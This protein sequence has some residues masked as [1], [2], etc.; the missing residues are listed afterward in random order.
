M[1][2]PGKPPELVYNGKSIEVWSR[3]AYSG[4]TNAIAA[5]KELGARAVPNLKWIVGRKNSWWRMKVWQAYPKL[6]GGVQAVIQKRV[7]RPEI[8]TPRE[9]AAFS[10]GLIGPAAKEAVPA[11]IKALGDG[12]GT[13][14]WK[15]AVALARIGG[16]SVPR[17][18][19]ALKGRNP[20][21]RSMAAYTLGETGPAS[22]PAIPGLIR[23][24]G[25]PVEAVR[26]ASMNSL[27]E[28]G[29]PAV[30]ALAEAAAQTKDAA[31]RATA[32]RALEQYDAV[33]QYSVTP[34]LIELTRDESKQTR[35]RAIKAIGAVRGG[36]PLAKKALVQSLSDPDREVQLVAIQVLEAMGRKG[37]LATPALS[38][39]AQNPDQSLRTAAQHALAQMQ[40]AGPAET[41][42]QPA[43]G[44]A[45]LVSN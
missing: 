5:V 28:L 11:L 40:N 34:V 43:S 25:D 16:D 22:I 30:L 37:R 35:I 8:A 9:A 38:Q 1:W 26:N 2:G 18:I 21:V 12:E 20:V 3:E 44:R 24:A 42:Q 19:K 45:K 39:L 14:A 23:A 10:L 41:A 13:V 31:M 33:K 29:P 6:P 32:T 27:T 15:A 36:L 17:L 4:D 7:A